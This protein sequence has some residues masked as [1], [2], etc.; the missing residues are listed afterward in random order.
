MDGSG[1]LMFD[2]PRAAGGAATGDRP[3]RPIEWPMYWM[4]MIE[5]QHMRNATLLLA[6]HRLHHREWRVLAWISDHRG[7]A[8]GQIAELAG[9]ERSTASKMIDSLERRGLIRR[10][11]ERRDRRRNQVVLTAA[12]RRKFAQTVPI[13]EG[14]FRS[15]FSGMPQDRFDALMLSLRDLRKRVTSADLGLTALPSLGSAHLLQ[16][17]EKRRTQPPKTRGGNA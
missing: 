1:R 10:L 16:K 8:I 5:K 11:A 9:L 3:F 4:V 15:Y 7:L 6:P 13:V 12:G 2:G 14:L 17:S